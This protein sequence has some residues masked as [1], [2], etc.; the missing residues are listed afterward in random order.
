LLSGGIPVR[1]INSGLVAGG[2]VTILPNGIQNQ[3]RLAVSAGE[4]INLYGSLQIGG[5]SPSFYLAPGATV[6][7]IGNQTLT[8]AEINAAPGAALTFNDN[9]NLNGSGILPAQASVTIRGD[10]AGNANNASQFAVGT[11]VNLNGGRLASS[12]Q[13]LEV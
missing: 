7:F 8:S 1:A 10:L 5:L 9:L 3:G 12:P 4:N 13:R 6:N 11:N 2:N